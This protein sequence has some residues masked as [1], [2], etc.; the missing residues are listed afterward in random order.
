MK[1]FNVVVIGSLP[2]QLSIACAAAALVLGECSAYAAG[3]P[4]AAVNFWNAPVATNQIGAPTAAGQDRPSIGSAPKAAVNFWNP[5]V[6]TN[7]LGAPKA[8]D[9][10][11]PSIGSAPK[12]AVNFRNPPVATN[13]I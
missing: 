6:A 11:R 5:P 1:L 2:R 7:Q 9:Q 12:A 4:K 13:Q 3:T 10:D 8:A